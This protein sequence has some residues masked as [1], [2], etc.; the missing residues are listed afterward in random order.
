MGDDDLGVVPGHAGAGEGGGD[1]GD[2]GHH[3]DLEAVFGGAQ[4]ADDA[5]EA[6]VAVGEDDGGAAVLGD[7]AGGEGETA[8][9]DAFGVR[10][11]FGQCEMVGGAGHERRGAEGGAGGGG[12]CG[13]VPSDHRDPVG[14][15]RQS[16]GAAGVREGAP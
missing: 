15:A 14:H 6:G 9:A 1:G 2:G 8:Q 5:E 10:G 11:D 12:Q 4:G 7:A 3:F 13:A 16:P